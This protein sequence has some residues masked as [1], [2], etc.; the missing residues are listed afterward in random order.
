MEI[1]NRNAF[2]FQFERNLHYLTVFECIS[3]DVTTARFHSFVNFEHNAVSEKEKKSEF[4]TVTS[5]GFWNGWITFDLLFSYRISNLIG[6][7]ISWWF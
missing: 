7:H 3:I 1:G 5:F 4:C 6:L 2:F